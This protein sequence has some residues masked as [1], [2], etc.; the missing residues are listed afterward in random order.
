MNKRVKL[1][2]PTDEWYEVDGHGVWVYRNGVGIFVSGNFISVPDQ[3]KEIALPKL[4]EPLL[5]QH[6]D[7]KGAQ[8]ITRIS[9]YNAPLVASLY[10]WCIEKGLTRS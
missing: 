10:S 3:W 7:D 8:R 6:F 1:F 9:D 2:S 4:W 5:K